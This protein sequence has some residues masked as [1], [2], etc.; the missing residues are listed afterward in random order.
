MSKPTL[1]VHFEMQIWQQKYFNQIKVEDESAVV[2]LAMDVRTR[3]IF[4]LVFSLTYHTQ[5]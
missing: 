4:I 5:S 2:F 1:F 3:V